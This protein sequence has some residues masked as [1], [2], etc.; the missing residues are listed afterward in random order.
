[1]I[2]APPDLLIVGGLAIDRLADR[3]TVAGGSVMHGARAAAASGRRVA[4]ITVAGPEPEA[5]AAIVELETLGPCMRTSVPASIRYAID[6][7]GSRR[8]LVFLGGG[9]EL[10]VSASDVAGINPRAVLLG[11]IAGEL[12]AEAVRACGTVPVR[13]AALQGWL[14]RLSPGDE[15]RALPLA[16]LDDEL[17]KALGELDALV[18]SDEDL[19][20]NGSDP[21]Q[22]VDMLRAHLGARPLLVITAGA[23]G[24]WLDDSVI[25]GHEVPAARRLQGLSMLGAGDAVAALLAI[26]LG[27]GL[28][29]LAA[30]ELAM[31]ETGDFLTTRRA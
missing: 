26:G 22:Q 7:E 17:S 18:V 30:T 11:P 9:A 19:A 23:A 28:D 8:R 31:R 12:S 29:P 25:G 14:R 20:A 3:S 4:T 21:L 24:A 1:M 15:V 5:D 10:V 13:V 27:M 2:A 16:A 6:D